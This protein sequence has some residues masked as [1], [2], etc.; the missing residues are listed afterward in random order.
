MRLVEDGSLP[1]HVEIAIVNGFSTHHPFKFTSG[2]LE[3]FIGVF[4]DIRALPQESY[5]ICL[6]AVK[7]L[8]DKNH[9]CAGCHSKGLI[10]L[11]LLARGLNDEISEEAEAEYVRR[12]KNTSKLKYGH[13][14]RYRDYEMD[15]VQ[16]MWN[17][18]VARELLLQWYPE[19]P[20]DD[21]SDERW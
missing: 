17:R 10:Y 6:D 11:K 19:L 9:D 20:G 15:V 1:D 5:R 18:R 8:V 16:K 21:S 14:K 2:Q 7:K 13:T 12:F 4:E 3:Q